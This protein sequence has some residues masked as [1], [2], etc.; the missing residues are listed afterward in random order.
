ME[1][2]LIRLQPQGAF[3]FGMQGIDMEI[4]SETC[5][6]DTLY[7][8]LFW[9]AL[10]QSHRWVAAPGN[11]PF[12]ISSC[13]P[14]V[15]GIQLLPVP[16]LPPLSSDE[17]K[18]SERKKFKKV[19]FIS[20]EIFINLLAGTRSLSHY[21]QPENGVSLQHGSVLVSTAEFKASQRDAEKPLW[22]IDSIPHVAVDRWS[23]A[24]AYYETGQVRFAP[25]CGLAILALG[26]MQH[27]MQ[28]LVEVGIDGLGG[29]RSK[30]VGQFEPVLQT[31]TLN[32]PAAT[33]DS[34]IV[35]SRYLPSAAELAAGVL[36]E[37]AAYSLEDVTG[38]MYSPA[39][40]AQ[41]RKA[42][43]MIGVGSRLNRAGLAHSIVGASV[44]VAPTYDN[45]IAG[46]SHPVWRHG[47]ALT[48]GCSLGGEQ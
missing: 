16:M 20:S 23:N 26:D 33:S 29:R 11:P 25:G 1:F 39:A 17:Q 22:K 40:K 45:H 35:L 36:A 5:P 46:V 47:L 37:P 14:Y 43:W 6:S 32:L 42:I 3:H 21:F 27:L 15:D 30:G 7:A 28:L 13:F 31:E 8:A 34:V 2:N 19:R 9:Q 41:R 12:T 10:Q 18:P 38:W 4:V 48:V 44:D 24:S